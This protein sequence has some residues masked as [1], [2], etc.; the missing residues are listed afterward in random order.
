MNCR[1]VEVILAAGADPDDCILDGMNAL[2]VCAT[3]GSLGCSELILQF[4]KDFVVLSRQ[5]NN[6]VDTS[7][8]LRA[9]NGGRDL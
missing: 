5:H 3:V 1:G 6:K 8:H 9:G 7:F 2:H 4:S